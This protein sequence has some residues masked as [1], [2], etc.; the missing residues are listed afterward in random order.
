MLH[1]VPLTQLTLVVPYGIVEL[2]QHWPCNKICL[3]ALSI[4]L[5]RAGKIAQAL[6]HKCRFFQLDE[7]ELTEQ[8]DM[9]CFNDTSAIR[10]SNNIFKMVINIKYK[11]QTLTRNPIGNWH[12]QVSASC[13]LNRSYGFGQSVHAIGSRCIAKV[14]ACC[15]VAPNHQLSH[16]WLNITEIPWHST[17]GIGLKIINKLITLMFLAPLT[18]VSQGLFDYWIRI[19]SVCLLLCLN[20]KHHLPSHFCTEYDQIW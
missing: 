11:A 3:P 14:M 2:S 9:S 20:A 4:C 18:S 7:N 10:L 8:E 17:K 5:N 1:F 13:A 19:V 16:W 15:L 12:C 6:Q